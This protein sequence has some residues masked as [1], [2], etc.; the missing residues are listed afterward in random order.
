MFYRTVSKS[1]PTKVGNEE[2]IF[3]NCYR[4]YSM[5]HQRCNKICYLINGYATSRKIQRLPAG[6]GLNKAP[7][8]HD[9]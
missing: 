4:Y 6:K 1:M 7:A 5:F 9:L 3:R 2:Q 8:E